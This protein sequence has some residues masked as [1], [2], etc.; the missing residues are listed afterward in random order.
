MIVKGG[1]RLA[2][3]KGGKLNIP[4]NFAAPILG[5]PSERGLPSFKLRAKPRKD[6]IMN[7]VLRGIMVA[8]RSTLGK[9]RGKQKRGKKGG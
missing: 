6:T 5:P 4:L 2:P 3:G 7:S 8:L 1:S 9:G